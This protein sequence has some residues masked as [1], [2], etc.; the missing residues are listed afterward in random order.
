VIIPAVT[1]RCLAICKQV[2]ASCCSREISFVSFGA[3]ACQSCLILGPKK[4]SKFSG[5]PVTCV[6]F[7]F[8]SAQRPLHP[9][10]TTTP[11]LETLKSPTRR[12]KVLTL[13]T[14]PEHQITLPWLWVIDPDSVHKRIV[15]SRQ[16]AE[17]SAP[18]GRQ[19]IPAPLRDAGAAV[20][21]RY[22]RAQ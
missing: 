15:S 14:Q 4:Q 19:R 10:E 5:I 8:P 11:H 20:I 2:C 18:D 7:C 22:H 6:P 21:A 16:M 9:R 13:R 3:Q 1:D 17:A 12:L